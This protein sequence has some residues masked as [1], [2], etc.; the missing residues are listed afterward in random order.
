MDIRQ[1]P[2]MNA[3]QITTRDDL[4]Q[5]LGFGDA[6]LQANRAGTLS[7]NQQGRL[8]RLQQRALMF[9][10]AGFFGFALLATIFIFMGQQNET[11]ILSFIG[12]MLTVCNAIY[13]GMFGR[14]WLRL[15]ADKRNNQVEALQGQLERIIRP[16]GRINNYVVRVADTD[17][18]VDKTVFKAFQHEARY[19]LYRAPHSYVLLAAERL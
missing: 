15:A 19:R 12:V 18:A 3:N 7:E 4:M 9:G 11:A 10:G 16:T 14:Q 17:F 1:E 5:A 6:D 2:A 13:I 8:S